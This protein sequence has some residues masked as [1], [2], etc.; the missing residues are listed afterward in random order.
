DGDAVKCWG[1]DPYGDWGYVDW[2]THAIPAQVMGV[3]SGVDAVSVGGGHVCTIS[4]AGRL[5]CWGDNHKGQL[6][7][8]ILEQHNVTVEVV[9]LGSGVQA[10]S[11][12]HEHTCAL[13]SD[14]GVRCWGYNAYGQL[15]NGTTDLSRTPVAVYGLE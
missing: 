1:Y 10:V 11:A 5:Q 15:G 4:G 8:G 12:G 13:T 6:G 3:G 9:G 7:N 2:I 14:G